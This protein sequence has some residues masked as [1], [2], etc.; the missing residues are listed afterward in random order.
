MTV[1]EERAVQEIKRAS[2]RFEESVNKQIRLEAM[3]QAN[4][5]CRDNM[6]EPKYSEEDFLKLLK[7]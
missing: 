6:Q 7:D 3:K 2:M 1:G 5:T 4:Q